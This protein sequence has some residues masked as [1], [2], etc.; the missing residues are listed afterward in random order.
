[1]SARIGSG[2]TGSRRSN[3]CFA[4]AVLLAARGG[5]R[6]LACRL[7]L[8]ARFP[9]RH[10]LGLG[11]QPCRQ[12]VQ[13][14]VLDHAV[15]VP[16]AVEPVRRLMVLLELPLLDLLAS[17]AGWPVDEVGA[18]IEEQCGYADPGESELIGAV[19]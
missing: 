14:C 15:K 4:P 12:H 3:M 10:G 6:A 5:Q 19:V 13:L 18:V 11:D 16:A 17:P 9:A 1:M 2:M 7:E 8:I